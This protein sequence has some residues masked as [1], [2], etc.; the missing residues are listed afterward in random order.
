M[1]L[2]NK[3]LM[4]HICSSQVKGVVPSLPKG[5]TTAEIPD[6]KLGTVSK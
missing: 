5:Q 3:D 1:Y 6:R 4:A 2:E